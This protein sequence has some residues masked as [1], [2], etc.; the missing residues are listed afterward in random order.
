MCRFCND[1]GKAR[2]LYLEFPFFHEGAEPETGLKLA[3]LNLR[4]DQEPDPD[5]VEEENVWNICAVTTEGS[6]SSIAY[7]C[8]RCGRQLTEFSSTAAFDEVTHD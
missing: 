2:V 7:Y 8:P 1:Q 5:A 4:A 6:M 3:R